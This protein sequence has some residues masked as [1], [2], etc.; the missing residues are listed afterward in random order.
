MEVYA[1]SEKT[2][3]E[4]LGAALWRTVRRGK[5]QAQPASRTTIAPTHAVAAGA[6]FR[7]GCKPRDGP[8]LRSLP[9]A[10]P[11]GSGGSAPPCIV[12]NPLRAAQA[13]GISNVSRCGLARE[14]SEAAAAVLAAFAGVAPAPMP[15]RSRAGTRV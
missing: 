1:D 4:G 9:S 11:L 13:A 10:V 5:G 12:R 7:A 6:T 8:W 14:F 3:R 2:Q 15:L